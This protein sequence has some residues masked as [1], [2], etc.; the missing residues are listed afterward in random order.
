[1][2]QDIY[3][4]VCIGV[5]LSKEMHKKLKQTAKACDLT[6]SQ[7]VRVAVKNLIEQKN[8]N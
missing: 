8:Q 4:T 3:D 5:R 7:F 2:K 6:I 1:M